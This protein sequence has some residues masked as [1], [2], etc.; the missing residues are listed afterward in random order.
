MIFANWSIMGAKSEYCPLFWAVCITPAVKNG[1]I[2]SP[3]V[4]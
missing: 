1:S 3:K 4:F 2:K